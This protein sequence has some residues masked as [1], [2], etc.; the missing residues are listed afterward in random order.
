M[1]RSG[2]SLLTEMLRTCGLFV[3]SDLGRFPESQLFRRINERLLGKAGASW[4]LVDRYLQQR[5]DPR[6]LARSARMV[7]DELDARFAR[8]FL[9]GQGSERPMTTPWGWKDPRTCITLPV[10]TQVFPD[11]RLLHIVRNPLDVAFSIQKREKERR[12]RGKRPEPECLDVRHSLVLW[13]AHVASVLTFRPG[14]DRYHE[15]R[16]EDL[17]ARPERVIEPVLRFASLAPSAQQRSDACALVD[18]SRA[19]PSDHP[20]YLDWSDDVGSL[21]MADRFGYHPPRSRR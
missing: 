14:S 6:F 21:A 10:W 13:E 5:E 18:R 12:A 9:G 2:T 20:Q 16:Y 17:L 4:S 7:D 19:R 1:H 11:A 8:G 3:G 15:L